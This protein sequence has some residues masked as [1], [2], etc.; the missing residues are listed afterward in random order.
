MPIRLKGKGGGFIPDPEV[1]PIVAEM[2]SR[3]LAG[4]SLNQLADWL[5]AMKIPTSRD[6]VRR[7]QGKPEQGT[8]WRATTVRK[9]LSSPTL[10]GVMTAGR[11]WMHR[12]HRRASSALNRR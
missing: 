11:V 6:V 1:A 3:F 10:T 4:E 9:V 5:N 12:M 7:R 8:E 2:A